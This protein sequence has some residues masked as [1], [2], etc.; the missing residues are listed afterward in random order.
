MRLINPPALFASAGGD[1]FRF[2]PSQ[3]EEESYAPYLT[4]RLAV[5]TRRSRAKVVKFM[6]R[7]SE[8]CSSRSKC[9]ASSQAIAGGWRHLAQV[10]Q[11]RYASQQDHDFI[12]FKVS[13]SL[14]ERVFVPGEVRGNLLEEEP[15]SCPTR[16]SS[17]SRL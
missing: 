15:W 9:I 13:K 2:S 4:T 1:G 16:D 3:V 12:G 11:N 8:Y 10:A 5:A 14:L 7:Q 6:K 17:P